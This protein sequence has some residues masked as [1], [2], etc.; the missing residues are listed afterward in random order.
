MDTFDVRK[1]ITENKINEALINEEKDVI[2]PDAQVVDGEQRAAEED[3]ESVEDDND[4]TPEERER[5]NSLISDIHKNLAK[6]ISSNSNLL[7]SEG[8]DKANFL[9][10]VKDAKDS[11]KYTNGLDE[12]VTGQYLRYE[13][14]PTNPQIRNAYDIYV[15]DIISAYF[16]RRLLADG[17]SISTDQVPSLIKTITDILNPIDINIPKKT[18]GLLN[19][20]KWH[21]ENEDPGYTWNPSEMGIDFNTK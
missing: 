14:E 3:K 8:F 11:Q 16:L 21:S 10:S 20:V 18:K 6:N 17:K 4:R 19:R 12:L 15:D 9:Q 7:D 5:L 13:D 2:D 1:Y